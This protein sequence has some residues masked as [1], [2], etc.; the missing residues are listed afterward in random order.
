MHLRSHAHIGARV[1][2][3]RQAEA[4]VRTPTSLSKKGIASIK[5]RLSP[6]EAIVLDIMLMQQKQDCPLK[7]DGMLDISLVPMAGQLGFLH[8]PTVRAASLL[9]GQLPAT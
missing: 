9:G 4:S 7:R 5:N 3:V 8:M 6:E 2:P 1:R